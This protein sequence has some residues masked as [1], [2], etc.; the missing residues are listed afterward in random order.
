MTSSS[1]VR[2]FL[3]MTFAVAAL[4]A[5]G[6]T[7]AA[8]VPTPGDSPARPPIPWAN[9]LFLPNIDEDRAQMPPLEIVHDFGTVAKGALLVHK[10]TLTNIYDAPMQVTELRRSTE[11]LVAYP[12]QR[13]VQP[14]E[15]A[16]FVVT[17]DTAKSSGLLSETVHVSVGPTFVSTAKLRVTANAR[18]DITLTPG[19]LNFGNVAEGAKAVQS[20]TLEY[21]GKQKDWKLVGAA[22]SNLYDTTTTDLG[23]GK[24]KVTVTLRPE[25]PA[26]PL[27]E[28][29]TLNTND[30]TVPQIR[31][32]LRAAIQGPI[33]VSAPR[34]VFT[35]L[36]VGETSSFRVI[37]RGNGVGEFTIEALSDQ[38]DG[39][40][41][42]TIGT[43]S[44]VHTIV[45]S[46]TP[47]KAGAFRTE[48]KLKTSLKNNAMVQLT[49]EG[50]AEAAA[51]LPK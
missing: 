16:D 34:I 42:Q 11:S 39:I 5:C 48:L 13:I 35:K 46:V 1:S 14:N 8:Q 41:V 30:P 38:G 45:V 47:V 37:V 51:A 26:G 25:A 33:E 27:N 43:S 9:K 36:K 10:F 32:G 23:R 19:S 12:P 31:V 44:P 18:A 28:T 7:A 50:D 4:L 3:K 20:V 2:R 15:K 49:V 40:T 24:F 29:L 21:A 6:G 22:A 17:L